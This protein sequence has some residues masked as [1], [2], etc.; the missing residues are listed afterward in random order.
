VMP[1]GPWLRIAA[2]PV[3]LVLAGGGRPGAGK[4]ERARLSRV[5]LCRA[6]QSR[7]GCQPV[8]RHRWPVR[9]PWAA[10][11]PAVPCRDPFAWQAPG[12]LRRL[13]A[14]RRRHSSAPAEERTR[15]WLGAEIEPGMVHRSWRHL[16]GGC[17]WQVEM[18]ARRCG[19]GAPPW[20]R[21]W[22]LRRWRCRGRVLRRQ[23]LL[24]YPSAGVAEGTAE[25]VIRA[26]KSP[27]R[28]PKCRPRPCTLVRR[29]R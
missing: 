5:E 16:S 24:P 8:Q 23:L 13:A 29:I 18:C 14:I 6:G 7:R 21:W 27:V 28:L 12:G 20:G 4:R 26:R 15:A 10:P 17:S 22:S 11:G 9:V 3:P 2:A 19:G 1:G 25:A